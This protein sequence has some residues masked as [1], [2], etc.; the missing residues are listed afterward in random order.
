MEL[1]EGK[2]AAVKPARYKESR[3]GEGFQARTSA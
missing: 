1:R 2:G 3:A